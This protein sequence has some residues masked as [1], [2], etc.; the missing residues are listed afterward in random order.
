LGFAPVTWTTGPTIDYGG[1][2]DLPA[3][4]PIVAGT[5]RIER[6]GGWI[7][8]RDG[9]TAPRVIG[10]GQ[11]LA[12]TATGRFVAALVPTIESRESHPMQLVVYRLDR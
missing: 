8:V 10:P 6:S 1:V 12:A 2:H 9:T 4:T 5:R 11:A 3:P 7:R